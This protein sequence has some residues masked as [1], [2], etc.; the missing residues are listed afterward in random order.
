MPPVITP[1]AGSCVLTLPTA[2]VTYNCEAGQGN[3]LWVINDYQMVDGDEFNSN[4][5][6][7]VPVELSRESTLNMIP[8]VPEDPE[9]PKGVNF[10]FD[11]TQT[12]ELTIGCS[13]VV[14]EVNVSP[15]VQVMVYREGQYPAVVCSAHL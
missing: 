5:V 14:D 11:Q 6:Q 3:A 2:N 1:A 13:A 9:A 4:G 15:P 12:D 10:F 8:E 7:I